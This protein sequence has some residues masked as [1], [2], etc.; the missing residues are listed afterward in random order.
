MGENERHPT[1]MIDILSYASVDH[2]AEGDIL[3]AD[4]VVSTL[5][6]ASSPGPLTLP[7]QTCTSVADLKDANLS[8]SD[9]DLIAIDTHPN[10]L[11]HL[12]KFGPTKLRLNCT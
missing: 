1:Y 4:E 9:V 5:L 2:K 12:A 3:N 7:P 6:L 11:S 8:S 10:L